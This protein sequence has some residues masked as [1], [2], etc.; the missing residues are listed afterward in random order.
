MQA[1]G[2]VF[3]IEKSNKL[4]IVIDVNSERLFLMLENGGRNYEEIRPNTKIQY[5]MNKA[6]DYYQ[7]RR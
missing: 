4:I 5:I 6:A 7:P 1:S 2:F 3:F